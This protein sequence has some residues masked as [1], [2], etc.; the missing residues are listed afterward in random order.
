[1]ENFKHQL[2]KNSDKLSNSDRIIF[3]VIITAIL[4][5]T[6]ICFNF[7]IELV[8]DKDIIWFD[9]PGEQNNL[10]ILFFKAIIIAPII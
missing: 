4:Y 5:I 2:Q 6:L 10:F 7:I 1:M 3:V 8:G 9:F